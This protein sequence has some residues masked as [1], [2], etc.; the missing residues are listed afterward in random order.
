MVY[1]SRPYR[2]EDDYARMR[3]LLVA[4]YAAGGPPVYGTV[5]DLDWW[6]W[7]ADDARIVGGVRLWFT[8][9]GE[10]IG[11]TWPGNAQVDV[12]AHPRH[13]TVEDGMLAWAEREEAGRATTRAHE[14]TVWAFAGDSARTNLLRRRGYVRSDHYPSFR[15]HDLGEPVPAP[16]L[17]AGYVLRHVRGP[18]DLDRRVA[19]HRDAFAPSR[20][21][22]EKHHRVMRAAT[23][24]QDLDLVVEAPDGS[25]AAY[26]IV[27]FDAA[28]RIGLFE[29]VG[30]HSAHRRRGLGTAIMRKGLRRLRSR[31][32][33]PHS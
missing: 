2:D 16:V 18:E 5:G 20:M 32:P 27:W 3:S 30:C 7:T 10:L 24:R 14:L 25:F 33:A 4:T 29:P 13:R 23:Y 31:A 21:T 11:F 22:V 19:V 12:M 6:R 9:D 17:P 15:R 26:C 1:N 8:H 28:N